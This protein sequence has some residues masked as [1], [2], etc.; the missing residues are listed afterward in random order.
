VGLFDESMPKE[1]AP[2]EAPPE[3]EPSPKHA[4]V[5]EIGKGHI[6]T[7]PEAEREVP[8]PKVSL[9]AGTAVEFLVV[10]TN[11]GTADDTIRLR[12]DLVY[13]SE[14]PESPEWI[15]KVHGVEDKVWDV[16]FTKEMEKEIRLIGGGSRE[17]TFEITCPRGARYGD[18]LNVVINA[19]SKEDPAASDAKTI[20]ATARQAV[21][22][23]KTS[24]GHER[25]VADSIASRAKAKEVGIFSILAPTNVR[26]YVFVESMNPDRLDEIVR[27]IRRARGVIRGETS[28]ADIEHYLTPKPIVSG[29]LEGDI[30]EL[31]A[32]PFKGEKARVMKIDETR[33]EITVEL[34]EAMV[35]IPVTV[36]GDH[37]R[38]I[39]KE[40]RR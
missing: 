20:T 10:V 9:T 33:E 39:E 2:V 21:M 34:F 37:V 29:I 17:M 19:I 13:A 36:R 38:V 3:R 27:G 11:T 31:I 5:L 32:G 28:V 35:R 16:S 4:V 14:A 15:V 25:S 8:E 22:A 6:P 30:V 18:R 7:A 23:V 40:G 26:G 24:I 1:E 12:L